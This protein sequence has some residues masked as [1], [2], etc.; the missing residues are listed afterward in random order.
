M[1]SVSTRENAASAFDL[2]RKM[3]DGMYEICGCGGGG[4]GGRGERGGQWRAYL[5]MS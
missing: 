3:G 4:S 2:Q 1:M 5:S